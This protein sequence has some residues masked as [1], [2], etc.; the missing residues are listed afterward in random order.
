[1]LNWFIYFGGVLEQKTGSKTLYCYCGMI[2]TFKYECN[3][4][5]LQYQIFPKT[6]SSI[7]LAISDELGNYKEFK[8]TDT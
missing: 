7:T 2:T 6:F 4:D 3:F 8:Q 1:M 5:I